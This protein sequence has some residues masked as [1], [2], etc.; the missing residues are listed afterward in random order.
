MTSQ[1]RKRSDTESTDALDLHAGELSFRRVGLHRFGR[2]MV[3]GVHFLN[4]VN[5]RASDHQ[6]MLG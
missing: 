3:G 4:W 6:V 5:S 1:R 2:R